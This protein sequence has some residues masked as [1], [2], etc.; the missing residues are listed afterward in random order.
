MALGCLHP[1][2]LIKYRSSSDA[3]PVQVLVMLSVVTDDLAR[4][5]ALSRI[6]LSSVFCIFLN[7]CTTVTNICFILTCYESNLY[8]NLIYGY[9]NLRGFSAVVILFEISLNK[10]P[11]LKNS[12]RFCVSRIGFI[13][14]HI[15][16]GMDRAPF[17]ILKPSVP[18]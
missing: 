4:F 12:A 3:L 18:H 6:P 16:H 17:L 8:C 10:C 2:N 5:V 1:V 14:F 9:T 15:S 7:Y 13:Q 11:D